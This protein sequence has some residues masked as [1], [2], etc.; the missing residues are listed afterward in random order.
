MVHKRKEEKEV[1]PYCKKRKEIFK[2]DFG[3]TICKS[4]WEKHPEVRKQ[5]HQDALEEQERMYGSD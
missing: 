4:C 5:F 2:D 3:L 1:C